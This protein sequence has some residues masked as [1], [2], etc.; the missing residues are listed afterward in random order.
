M[1]E[2]Q[3]NESITKGVM[4]GRTRRDVS[5]E[6]QRDFERELAPGAKVEIVGKDGKKRAYDPKKYAE[7]VA[8]TR[9]SEA[10]T[11]GAINGGVEAGLTLFRWSVHYDA[12]PICQQYQGK[13][14][15]IDENDPDFPRL[16]A[17]PP[18]HPHC[19]HRLTAVVRGSLERRGQLEALSKLSKDS[20]AFI[21]GASDY[22]RVIAGGEAKREA[23]AI[24]QERKEAKSAGRKA[25]RDAAVASGKGNEKGRLNKNRFEAADRLKLDEEERKDVTFVQWRLRRQKIE[26]GFAWNSEGELVVAR[27]GDE[28]RVDFLAEE[29][30]QGKDG[31]FVHN[32]PNGTSF[33]PLDLYTASQNRFAKSVLVTQDYVYE[34]SPKR[35]EWPSCDESIISALFNAVEKK[36]ENKDDPDKTHAIMNIVSEVFGLLY[37]RKSWE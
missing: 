22:E 23:L 14:Y 25:R 13:I 30:E 7:L 35:R 29:L 11:E 34:V 6:I 18:I 4:L 20:G 12:C 8:R 27:D 2:R 5:R 26:S 3:L 1:K 36:H 24:P 28:N 10:V 16:E 32:H 21:H 37:E 15:S 17:R 19:E 9:T 33:S 31:I